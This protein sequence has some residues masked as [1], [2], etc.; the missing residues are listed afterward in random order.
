MRTN[1]LWM[2]VIMMILGSTLHAQD[3]A[4]DWQG[5]LRAGAQELRLIVVFDKA[6]DGKWNATLRSIDQSPDWGAGVSAD[7]VTL[8]ESNLKFTIDALRG[9]FE[10]KVSANGGTMEGTWTQGPPLPL[11]FRRATPETAWKDPSPHS[12]RFVTVDTA[13]VKLEV[14]DW[15]GSGRPLVLLAGLGN[16]AHIFD[17]FAP[18]LTATYHVYGIT[19]RGFGASSAPPPSVAAYSADRLGDDVLAVL[20][21]LKLNRPVLAGHSLAGEELSSVGSRHPERIAGLIY[22]DAGYSYAYYDQ[23][24][25]DLGI[26]LADLQKKLE[27][28]QPGNS[29]QDPKRLIEELLSTTLPGFVRDL[30]DM[31]K[32]LPEVGTTQSASAAI[33]PITRAIMT[34]VQKY[35]DIRVPVLAIYALP[36]ATGQ[37][38]KDDAA[39]AAADAQ[40]EAT[41][42]AQAKAFETGVPSA[43]VIRLAHAN[44][45]VFLSNEPEVLREIND[46]L[47]NLH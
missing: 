45:Y 47:G 14:L 36:H 26:D 13:Q 4:G 17:K 41:T 38:F 31:Q 2:G 24:R 20:D 11:E 15:G 10:G 28:L 37:P 5:T 25:G 27:Q 34:G 6:V 21:A 35:T 8:Q 3:I 42:G 33:P 39:R 16:T 30:K 46:F 32:N 23:S 43:R 18:K 9:G 12:V 1:T 44:H 40:D 19:R 29:P 7:S 22:L